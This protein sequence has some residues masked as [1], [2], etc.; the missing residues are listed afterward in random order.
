MLRF[1]LLLC[2]SA[3]FAVATTAVA[4]P[5]TPRAGINLNGPSDWNSELP[6]VDV[7]RQSREWISQKEG[8]G[9]GQGPALDIDER[10]WVRELPDGVFAE[11]LLM[12]I[13]GG[14]YPTGEYTVLYD[15]SGEIR[16]SGARVVSS[17]PGRMI[18]DVPR[19]NG[20][21]L[22][23][24][25]TDPNDYIRN[26]RVIMPGFE[27]VYE[28]NPFH[29]VFLER[30]RGLAAVRFMDWMHTNNSTVAKWDD[31]TRVDDATWSPGIPLEVMIDYVN[32]IEVDPWFCIPHKADDD[33][34]R[35]FAEVVRDRLDPGLKVYIEYSNEVWN[36]QFR[37]HHDAAERGAELGLS[38]APWSNAWHYTAVRSVEVF[39]IFEEVFN[40]TDRL[41]RVLASQSGNPYVAEQIVK[42]RDAYRHADALA[43]GP[44]FGF[45]INAE[46]AP[47]WVERGVGAV[48]DHIE[49][50]TLPE[51][52]EHI[53]G[54]K[55]VADEHGL[56]LI[57]YEAGQHLVGYQ[58]GENNDALTAM[59][60]E[61]NRHP[62]MGEIYSRYLQAWTDAGGGLLAHFSSIGWWS[63][64]GSWGLMEHYNS[65]P[66]DYPKYGAFMEWARP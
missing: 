1:S 40:G 22:Q 50:T 17:E 33:Y 58:G 52:I 11:T 21:F 64:W 63:K 53:R 38:D 37:Q 44:Y 6:F 18:I 23:I 62:R 54:N 60:H 28:D 12:T 9:W 32:R 2:L 61:A 35:N 14:H 41:V 57:A 42:F 48:L 51:T 5:A 31:R 3:A 13:E 24:R 47:K 45:N 39:A 4:D 10:G 43:I 27:S 49:A 19:G 16:F 15:G 30:W 59:L 8:A 56:A 26:I 20:I 46:D 55:R 34:V 65:D 36:G 66:A 29:P 7:F 25:R